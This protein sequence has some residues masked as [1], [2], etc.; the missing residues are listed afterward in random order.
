MNRRLSP[1]D[2]AYIAILAALISICSWLS[3]PAAVPI[4]LQTFAVFLAVFVLGGRRGTLCVAVY[5]L[6]GAIGLPVFSYF[7]G[8]PAAL[9]GASGGYLLGFIPAALV[10][11]LLEKRTKGSFLRRLFAALLALAVC[12]TIGTLWYAVFYLETSPSVATILA[13]CVLPFILPDLLKLSFALFLSD[14]LR[15]HLNL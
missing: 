7:R 2:M 4:T 3:I 12:Y 14:R 8:G 11:W 10:L 6:L 1:R 9:F 13:T 5:L 15:K